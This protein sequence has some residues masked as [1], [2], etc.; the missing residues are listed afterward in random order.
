MKKTAFLTLAIVLLTMALSAKVLRRTLNIFQNNVPETEIIATE[1]MEFVYDYRWCNDTTGQLQDNFTADQMLLQI[2]PG[3]LSKFS[4]YKNLTVDSLLTNISQ[5]Q[6]AEAALDG[7]LSNGEFM[8]IFKNYPHGR[9]THSE[10]ICMD[11]F[12]YEEEMPEIHWELTDS[13][14]Y[15]LG[16]KC[17]AAVCRFHG[18]EWTAFYA[19]D[20]PLMEGPWKL[21]GLPGLIL[22]AS[23]NDGHY[24]FECI[25]I[26]S[27]A[28][29]PITVYKVPY[30]TTSRAKYY[31]TKHRYEVNPYAYFE[32]GGHG[33]ITVTDEAGNPSLDA[34][35]PIELHYDYI[36]RDW[37]QLKQ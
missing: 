27:K 4:S 36:E 30:V 14:A 15:I 24:L 18:R 29:R 6:V 2:G 13:S 33:H 1:S 12:R 22:K 35:D 19:E 10:K 20:I 25:G 9:I 16:Y 3:G 28:E 11:W 31:D 5:E 26:K 17:S 21:H 32:E 23:D 7:K 8:T 37:K 34:Y